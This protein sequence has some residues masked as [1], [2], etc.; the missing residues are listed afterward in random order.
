MLKVKPGNNIRL[1]EGLYAALREMIV[2][3]K[4]KGGDKL[5]EL[6]LS[7][8]LKASR[9]PLREAMLQLEQEGLVRSDLRRGFSVEP[10]STQEVQETYP[11]IARLEALAV[12]Q[13]ADLLP[14][15][16]P[17]LSAINDEFARARSAQRALGLD[18]VWHDTLMSQCSNRRLAAMVAT[19]RR[20]IRRYEHIYM[21]DRE[22]T[23]ISVRQHENIIAAIRAGDLKAT[24]AGIEKN[25]AFGMQSL[26]KDMSRPGFDRSRLK[27]IRRR[28]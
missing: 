4:L 17:R 9:T 14:A 12:E 24:I 26:L 20:A 11:V 28:S 1:R 5:N 27:P 19:L 8:R 21:A 25:Y 16:L 18:T 3:G 7:R 2:A 23:A 22:L 6:E 10:L 15:L 13:S